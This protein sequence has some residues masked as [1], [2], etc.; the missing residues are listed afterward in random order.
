MY[1]L[2]DFCTFLV[3]LVVPSVHFLI[4]SFSLFALPFQFAYIELSFVMWR[5]KLFWQ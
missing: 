2:G 4:S 1:L 3:F 5:E